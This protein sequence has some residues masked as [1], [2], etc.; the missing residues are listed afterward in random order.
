M[1]VWCSLSRKPETQETKVTYFCERLLVP[2]EGRQVFDLAFFLQYFLR[3]AC[4]PLS[5][6]LDLSGHPTFRM[7]PELSQISPVQLG[8]TARMIENTR[9]NTA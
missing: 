4:D 5:I 9:S 7:C 3:V 2:A 8:E 6:G 1:K